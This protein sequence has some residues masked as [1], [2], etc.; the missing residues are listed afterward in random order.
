[1][2]LLE[3]VAFRPGILVH[4]VMGHGIKGA[5]GCGAERMGFGR[6][7]KS[8]AN[9][10][11]LDIAHAIRELRLGQDLGLVEAFGPHVKLAFRIR[12]SLH[13]KGETSLD[14]LDGFFKRDIGSR[15]D[16]CVEMV[17]HDDERVQEKFA[18]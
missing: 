5:T 16:E 12:L 3:Q 7:R 2:R 13:A 14:E 15:C 6:R 18:L 10:I 11:L 17:R 4:K 1:M 8:T 9:G